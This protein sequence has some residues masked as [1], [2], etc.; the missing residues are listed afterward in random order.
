MYK[1][2]YLTHKVITHLKFV[3]FENMK[4]KIND[5]QVR[6]KYN[7]ITLPYVN[8]VFDHILMNQTTIHT[9]LSQINKRHGGLT[10]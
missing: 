7:L 6:Y 4:N 1:S 8:L 9:N 5:D 10:K 3:H 2:C